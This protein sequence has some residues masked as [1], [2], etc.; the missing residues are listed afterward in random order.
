MIFSKYYEYIQEPCYKGTS[1]RAINLRVS[2][3][4]RREAIDQ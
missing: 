2:V 1:F 4:A 3:R